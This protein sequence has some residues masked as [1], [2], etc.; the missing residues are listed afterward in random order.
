[1]LIGHIAG[2]TR[3][4]GKPADWDEARDGRCQSLPV[5]DVETP[6][7]PAMVSAWFPSAEDIA[8]LAAG[9]PLHLWIYGR[10]HPVVAHGVAPAE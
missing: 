6:A 3:D 9:Q 5:L 4:L 8:Q 10:T 7:G 1:M 2:A